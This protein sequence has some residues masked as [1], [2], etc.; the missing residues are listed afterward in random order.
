MRKA[1]NFYSSFDEVMQEFNTHEKGIFIT[2]MLDVQFMR[3]HID[4]ITFEDRFLSI[5]WKAIKHSVFKQLDGYCKANKDAYTRGLFAYE[6]DFN[7]A[8]VQGEGE[9]QEEVQVQGEVAST[10]TQIPKK[11]AKK[12]PS[13]D[14][15]I[16]NFKTFIEYEYEDDAVDIAIDFI[17]YRIEIK[18]PIKTTAAIVLFM[19][20][21]LSMFNK[22]GIAMVEKEILRMK[23][24]GW[25]T[26]YP[27]YKK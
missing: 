14:S 20:E 21:V 26:L 11:K 8:S 6:A 17:Y 12:K 24:G 15:S 19:N 10:D 13:N 1:F 5:A 27:A 16:D 4:D 25:K 7:P 22:F 23:A 9:V 3:I 2:A 18:D